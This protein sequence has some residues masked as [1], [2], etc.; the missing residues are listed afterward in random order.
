[1]RSLDLG[2]KVTVLTNGPLTTLAKI[3]QSEKA[4]SMI[5]VCFSYLILFFFFWAISQVQSSTIKFMLSCFRGGSRI[6][7]HNKIKR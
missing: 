7:P 5:Q 6:N 1:M 2:S 3:I 4:S